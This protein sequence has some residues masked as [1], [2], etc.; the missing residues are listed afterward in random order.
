ME[1]SWFCDFANIKNPNIFIS[2]H[3]D[4]LEE[5]GRKLLANNDFLSS[6]EHSFFLFLFEE[7]RVPA[8]WPLLVL[9]LTLRFIIHFLP[10]LA[11]AVIIKVQAGG[12]PGPHTDSLLCD[13]IFYGAEQ[14]KSTPSKREG[15]QKRSKAVEYPSLSQPPTEPGNGSSS[16]GC[17]LVKGTAE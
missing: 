6:P 7:Q 2:P 1:S 10:F 4:Q 9:T 11:A 14:R 17:R 16:L 15:G 3:C 5:E 8:P 13:S 12:A